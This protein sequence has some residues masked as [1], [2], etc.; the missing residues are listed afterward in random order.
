[1]KKSTKALRLWLAIGF[2]F[3]FLAT[4]RAAETEPVGLVLSAP[5]VSSNEFKFTLN[6][7]SGVS[8]TIHAS[9]NLLD[10]VTVS[11][12]HA[13]G[14]TRAITITNPPDGQSFYRAARGPLPLFGFALAAN[15][16]INLGSGAV[17]DSYDSVYGP[18]SPTNRRAGGSIATN[19]RQTNAIR[20]GTAH[21]YGTVSTGPG[22]IVSVAGGA[23]GAFDWNATQSGI[24][25]GWAS[26]DMNVAFPANQAPSGGP[27][28]AP[29]I[30][31]AGATNTTWLSS[32]TYQL[33]SFTSSSTKPMV[34]SGNAT[35]VVDGMLNVTLGGNITI[36]PGASL[37]LYVGGA[38]YISGSGGINQSGKPA[39]FTYYG[40]PTSTNLTLSGS[41]P[42]VGT[43]NA[44][45]ATLTA[46]G[47]GGIYGAAIVKSYIASGGSGFHYDESL[48][49]SGPTR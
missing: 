46:S 43:I 20:V 36:L 22:G 38:G 16:L 6:A 48:A 40:L 18:Y 19:S 2:A 42:F 10:W 28:P 4:A 14:I 13:P 41:A 49:T 1:L 21:V 32:G 44:P 26:D 24:Q 30:I 12:N 33:P 7:E 23:V 31:I 47:T 17:V 45:Q 29:P 34:V 25:P 5:Y 8:Y 3:F 37:T 15:G 9:T 11:T 39:N 35:L 27:F